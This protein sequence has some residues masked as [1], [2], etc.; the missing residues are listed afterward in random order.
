LKIVKI[1]LAFKADTFGELA[2]KMSAPADALIKSALLA[3]TSG[4]RV[5]TK[6]RVLDECDEPLGGLYLAG[7]EMA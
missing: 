6:L 5:N 2:A 4:F 1:G 7:K 3:T